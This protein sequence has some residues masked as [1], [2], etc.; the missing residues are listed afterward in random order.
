MKDEQLS[1]VDFLG[2]FRYGDDL[3]QTEGSYLL[4]T[5]LNMLVLTPKTIISHQKQALTSML[6]REQGWKFQGS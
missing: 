1:T 3:Q 4:R 6:G 2:A 5:P